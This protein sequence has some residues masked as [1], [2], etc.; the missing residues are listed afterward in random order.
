MPLVAEV[1]AFDPYGTD[2]FA[3]VDA[4]VLWCAPNQSSATHLSILSPTL[5]LCAC[6][7]P[8]THPSTHAPTHSPTHPPTHPTPGRYRLRDPP[9]VPWPRPGAL[10]TLP[11]DRIIY[12]G[13]VRDTYGI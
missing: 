6:T 4:G 7:H 9:A 13:T 11:H 8:P 3:W 10:A 5:H 1:A 2:W 12:T